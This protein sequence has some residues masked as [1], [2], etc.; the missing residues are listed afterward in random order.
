MKNRKV[1]FRPILRL[2]ALVLSLASL[3]IL[4]NCSKDSGQG[5]TT[6]QED[7][8]SKTSQTSASTE[9]TRPEKVVEVYDIEYAEKYQPTDCIRD[10]FYDSQNGNT[11]PYC[12]FVPKDYSPSK[13]YPVLLFLHGAGE[14]GT[15]NRRQLNNLDNM[16][17][18]NG[19]IVADAFILCPQ[20]AGWWNLDEGPNEFGGSLGS[21]LHLLNS[22]TKQYSCDKNRLYVMGLSMGGYAT[23]DL[24]ERCGDVFAA[25]VPICGGGNRYNGAAYK[26]IPIKIYHGTADTTVS[27][28]SSLAM[29][30][31]IIAAGG[32]KVDFIQ[33]DGVGHNAWDYAFSDREMFC[34]MFAQNKSKSDVNYECAPLFSV[35]DSNGKAVITD[36][37]VV[38]T[39]YRRE[40]GKT[41]KMIIELTLTSVGRSKLNNA[42]KKSNGSPFT[43]YYGTQKVYSFTATTGTNDKVFQIAEV[44]NIDNYLKFYNSIRKSD[45]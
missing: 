33:L 31:A 23:W 20:S 22:I 21:A 12:L 3:L 35:K 7:G 42:Y 32:Q 1:K 44:F 26:D 16:F 10:T 6:S 15:D 11:L 2:V 30:N 19:D 5:D 25:G 13:K 27:F 37:D 17:E 4:S 8:A 36:S 14:T 45:G 43:F 24:L 9:P 34:W 40:S 41:D 18:Y 28:S 39:N 29:Y 38:K